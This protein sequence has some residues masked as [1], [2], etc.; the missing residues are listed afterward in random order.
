[1]NKKLIVLAGGVGLTLVGFCA[2]VA[3][4]GSVVGWWKFDDAANPGKDS[5]EYGND[6]TTR[7]EHVSYK[8]KDTGYTSRGC[9]DD[10]GCLYIGAKGEKAGLTAKRSWDM[11]KGHTYL[12]RARNDGD[13]MSGG[14][15]EVANLVSKLSDKNRWHLFAERYDDQLVTGGTN[16]HIV[17][18]FGDDPTS[19]DDL[20][21]AVADDASKVYFPLDNSI[22]IGGKIGATVTFIFDIEKSINYKGYLDDVCV[23]QRTMS[24]EEVNYYYQ[25]GD[26][27]PYLKGNSSS[28]FASSDGWSC[29]GEGL[30][31]SPVNLPGAD[32][33]VD[34]GN[35]LTVSSDGTFGGHSLVLGRLA[36]AV[37]VVNSS[38]HRGKNGNLTANA[39]L[40]FSDLRLFSGKLTGSAGKT[41]T[42]TKL[43]VN[44]TTEDPFEI[45][46]A[47]GTYVI[48][49]AATG[50]GSLL[51]TGAGTLDL[52][53]LTGAAKVVV[54]EG[55]VLAGPNVTVTYDLEEDRG[56]VPVLM[57]E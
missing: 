5:S 26:P 24:K 56:A 3:P 48:G 47:S 31:Y 36:D 13:T 53:G 7:G 49:G 43:T 19:S 41:L 6:L 37:S 42:A 51:K 28:A 32:F 57:A 8:E 14:S 9:Y 20:A 52:T 33:Q 18:L 12:L 29:S 16:K 55:K 17:W 27:N 45:A 2:D 25:Y 30:G 40:A 34:D 21:Q 4:F 15:D 46:V 23:V 50:T 35:T 38:N 1:M 54:T 22:A 39:N 44:A 11:A 10:S